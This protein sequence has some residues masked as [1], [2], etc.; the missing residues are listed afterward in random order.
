M[1]QL[2]WMHVLE[3]FK[4]LV[5]NILFMYFLKNS[6]PDDNMQI[7]LHE[8]KHQVQILIVFGLYDVQKSDYIVM[9]V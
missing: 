9:A 8:I 4:K 6:G 5:D 1:N 7:C 3:G 2:T